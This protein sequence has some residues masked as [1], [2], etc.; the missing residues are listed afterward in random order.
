MRF[1]E[2]IAL[3]HTRDLLSP[4][5]GGWVAP[6]PPP[7]EWSAAHAPIGSARVH[8]DGSELT[9]VT[10]AN[11]T[12]MS[13]RVAQR[14]ADDGIDVRVVDVRWLVPLPVADILREAEAT[15][16]VLIVDE[17]RRSGG[18]SEGIVGALVDGLRGDDLAGDEP[19]L[20]CSIGEAA[21]HV[22]LQEAEIDAAARALVGS[23]EDAGRARAFRRLASAGCRRA[24]PLRVAR[25]QLTCRGGEG[26]ERHV[27]LADEARV[28]QRALGKQLDHPDRGCRPCDGGPGG[29]GDDP[30][31]VHA[32]ELL[33]GPAPLAVSNGRRVDDHQIVPDAGRRPRGA[34]W[35]P[36]AAGQGQAPAA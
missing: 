25:E 6:Y 19:G 35:P 24:P 13:L 2:P 27:L 5:D 36:L 21:D 9:I 32:D 22:L 18:V 12:Y 8:G 4:G 17:T 30:R 10:F 28:R 3:Y 16:R 15:G 7:S 11:G 23:V 29:A 1:L 31:A 34:A 20:L 26:V 33:A 14:L